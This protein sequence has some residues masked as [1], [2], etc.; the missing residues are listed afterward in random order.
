[1]AYGPH[2]DKSLGRSAPLGP[3]DRVAHRFNPDLGPGRI[4]A[5]EGRTLVVRFPLA[6]TTLKIAAETDVLDRVEVKP[7]V[8]ALLEGEGTEVAVS[9]VLDDGR[10]RLSDGRVVADAELWPLPRTSHLVERLASGE[11]DRLEDFSNRIDA[12]HLAAIR[13]ANGLG[14]FLGGRIQLFPHQLYVAERASRTD[15]VRWLLADEVGLGKTVEACLIQS[16]LIRT[17]RVQQVLVVAPATLTVQWLGELW[18]KYHQVY[19]LLDNKRLADVSRDY[20]EAFNPFE[21]HRQ[22]VISL[23]LLV[24]RPRLSEQAV[25]AGIDLLIVDEAHHLRRPEGHPGEPAYRAVEPIARAAPNVLLLTATPMEDDAHGFLRLLQLL[26]PEEFPEGKPLVERLETGEP[27]PACTSVTRRK[28]LGGLPPRKPRP[29]DIGAASLTAFFALEERL[30][31]LEAEGPV[32]IERKRDW[33]RRA[34]S[35]GAAL[36]PALGEGHPE[37]RALAARADGE[38]PRLAWLAEAAP[39]WR[40]RGEKTLVFVSRRETLELL[41]EQ[42]SHRAQI[43]TGVFHEDLSPARRDIEVAHFRLESGPSMLISTECGGEGRNFEFCHRLV[44]FD[45]PW[46]PVQVEQRIGRLDRIGRRMPVEVIYFRPPG[47]L[48]AAVVQLYEA[49]GLMERPL[50][51]LQRELRRIERAVGEMAL[52][53]EGPI[54]PHIFDT[55]V[56]QAQQAYER[57][58]DAAYRE[59]HRDLYDPSMA[60]AILARVPP[61]LEPLT[62]DVVLEAAECLGLKVETQRE[63]TVWSIELGKEAMVETLPGLPEGFGYV[64]TFDRET[65]V[66]DEMLDFFAAGHPLVEGLL[67]ELDDSVRG[68]TAL[69]QM[70]IGREVGLAL[71]AFYKHPGGFEVVVVDHRGRLRPDW[72]DLLR[73]RPLRTKHVDVEAWTSQPNWNETIT[74]LAPR[75]ERDDVPEAAA[76]LLV[77]PARATRAPSRS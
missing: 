4:L 22:A 29:V 33:M 31:R 73:R 54:D 69:L 67:T 36:I 41:R 61:D 64:G 15:P 5:I 39:A 34:H 68:R 59:L 47:G 58:Q 35:S 72:A 63:E 18:R 56:E 43:R 66:D 20:G 60:E 11:I 46:S 16:H 7:G 12:L 3:G 21:V 71:A 9:E 14:S 1:M 45:L 6:E 51:G 10:C 57:V 40:D 70:E 52:S 28:D 19:V 23:E 13:E 42:M 55:L 30:R 26:R 8:R 2:R 74:R 27:L 65:A 38:D 49:I 32:A 62:E 50:E 25:E 76:V 75:L 17:G 44:M 53:G 77:G 48:A 24:E 37:L